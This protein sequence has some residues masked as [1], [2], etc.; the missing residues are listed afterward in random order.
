[1]FPYYS[2][3]HIR[4][5]ILNSVYEKNPKVLVIAGSDSGGGAGIQA[6]LKSISANGAYA[7]TAITSITAQNT[8]GVQAISDVPIKIIEAQINSVLSDIGAHVI[9]TGM[10]SSKSI[11]KAV[12]KSISKYKIPLVLDPVMVAKGGSKLLKRDAISTLKNELLPKAYLITPNI[13]EAEVLSGMKIKNAA[14]MEKA[15]DKIIKKYKCNAVLVKGG[16]LRGEELVDI[17]MQKDSK[18]SSGDP[19][20]KDK[21]KKHSWNRLHICIGHCGSYSQSAGR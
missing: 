18:K 17:L 12:S 6:D 5:I 7:A 20:E 11:I 1:M 10:L 13:P 9:K 4:N 8:V 21:N 16:H 14:D 19:G 15:A 2:L 3:R